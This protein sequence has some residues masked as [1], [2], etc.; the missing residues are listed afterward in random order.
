[1]R[2]KP[3]V[4]VVFT[5]SSA[6]AAWAGAMDYPTLRRQVMSAPTPYEAANVVIGAGNQIDIDPELLEEATRLAGKAEPTR[7]D[8]QRL[9][10][11]VDLRS[12]ASGQPEIDAGE[13]QEQARTIAQGPGFSRTDPRESSNWLDR[14]LRHVFDLIARLFSPPEREPSPSTP[15]GPA[16]WVVPA[17][18]VI[19]GLL[20]LTLGVAAVR[21]VNLGEIKLRRRSSGVMSDDEVAI[22]ESSWIERAERA[23]ADG[24]PREAVRAY[25]LAT[26]VRIADAGIVTLVPQETNWEHLRR[27]RSSGRLPAAVDFVL[28]TKEFDRIWYGRHPAGEAEL[29]RVKGIYV[30]AQ[31]ELTVEP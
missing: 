28:S 17:M 2:G 22:A 21:L 4:R 31:R 25:Y 3:W 30:A 11:M 20:L 23:E 13:L 10:D 8:V 5:C 15:V 16:N 12:I 14:G 9:A 18:W 24:D 27:I 26:L 1:M 7:A 29:T 19:L 6:V